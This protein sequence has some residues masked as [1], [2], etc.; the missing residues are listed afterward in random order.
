[1]SDSLIRLDNIDLTLGGAQI[2]YDVSL[3]LD[4]GDI[5]VILG[6]SGSGKT[7]ILRIILGLYQPDRGQVFINGTDITQIEDEDELY[8]I[9]D[10]MGMVFQGG[11]LFDS[12]TVGENI[13]YR[14]SEK[15]TISEDV[16]EERVRR[17]L[18]FVDMEDSIDMM[19]AELS[20]GMKKRVAI[21]RGIV[22]S[23]KILLYDEPTAG[24]DPINAYNV[25]QLIARLSREEGITSVVVTHDL[26]CA[27]MI[28]TKIAFIQEGRMV[29]IGDKEGLINSKEE[30]VREF[31]VHAGHIEGDI[32]QEAT[33]SPPGI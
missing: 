8:K 21:A 33:C 4:E 23:P 24:L 9:R 1:M 22:S 26:A 14:L 10:M 29:Y 32:E 12:L 16:I 17:S 15:R 19:P 3:T 30:S 13:A 5:G 20:G 27:F 25:S 18:C 11:A 6:A 28:A 2:L 31:L 7:T